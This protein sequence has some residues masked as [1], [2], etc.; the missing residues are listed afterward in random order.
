[1]NRLR[2]VGTKRWP[3]IREDSR[4]G[5]VTAPWDQVVETA[6]A[7]ETHI[8]RAHVAIRTGR[9]AR[10]V[11]AISSDWITGVDR[12]FNAVITI[13][14]QAHTRVCIEVT[15]SQYTRPIVAAV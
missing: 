5:A 6:E 3:R 2:V 1:M 8:V 11:E 10:I 7:R 13:N 12:A 14:G 4:R 9:V 15:D